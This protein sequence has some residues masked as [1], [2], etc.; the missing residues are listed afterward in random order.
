MVILEG[1]GIGGVEATSS[2]METIREMEEGK[3]ARVGETEIQKRLIL[4]TLPEFMTPTLLQDLAIP[5]LHADPI[6][7]TETN[8]SAD[9]MPM[10]VAPTLKTRTIRTEKIGDTRTDLRGTTSTRTNR[11]GKRETATETKRVHGK[12]PTVTSVAVTE[13]EILVAKTTKYNQAT[14][15]RTIR[16]TSKTKI[17]PRQWG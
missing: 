13:T 16:I 1:T 10:T 12:T 6:A 17:L 14:V 7:E 5:T 4:V 3:I 9:R 15:T 8:N 11:S 2:Q